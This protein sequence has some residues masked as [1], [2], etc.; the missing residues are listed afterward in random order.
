MATGT[1]KNVND[2]QTEITSAIKINGVPSVINAT[3]HK[4]LEN[5]ETL[6]LKTR[7]QLA[8]T[9]NLSSGTVDFRAAE[10][11]GIHLFPLVDN[12]YQITG[13]SNPVKGDEIWLVV[14]NDFIFDF[15]AGFKS[16]NIIHGE[17]IRQSSGI[18]L[19]RVECVNDQTLATLFRVTYCNLSIAPGYSKN[20]NNTGTLLN[21]QRLEPRTIE[22][23]VWD[24]DATAT[25]DVTHGVADV[26][27]IRNVTVTISQDNQVNYYP[28]GYLSGGFSTTAGTF[29]YDNTKFA[30][31]RVATGFFDSTAFDSVAINRGW[32]SFDLV[33]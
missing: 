33:L 19:I 20:Y 2:L 13:F 32:V 28:I 17:Y 1:I 26:T 30:L 6:S 9:N 12:S 18:N 5:N 10:S 11:G 3:D 8:V 16:A 23:G 31:G 25:R 7:L 24:M 29:A 15:S 22:I 4:A 27:K 21:R 14:Y